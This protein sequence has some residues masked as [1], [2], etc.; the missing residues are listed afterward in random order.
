MTT[1]MWAQMEKTVEN[2][3]WHREA[4]VATH[5]LMTMQKFHESFSS[6]YSDK[7]QVVGLLALLFHDTGKPAAE[8][9]LEKK[10]GSGEKYRRYAG[11]EQESAVV[12][13]QA[14]LS[15]PQ[16]QALV[17]DD[18][19]RAIRWM[20]EHHLPYGYKDKQKRQGL[21]S[22]TFATFSKAGLPYQLFFDCLRS[23]AAG[24]I[25]DDHEKKLNDVEEWISE[26]IKID[27]QCQDVFHDVPLNGPRLFLLSGVSGSGKSTW[28]RS[29]SIVCRD[30]VISYDAYR[31]D[32]YR[33]KN[34]LF[35]NRSSVHDEKAEYMIAWQFC[36]ENSAEFQKFMDAQIN[37]TLKFVSRTGGDIYVDNTNT[38]RKARARFVE[39]AK[40]KK[41]NVI[42]VEFW[43]RFETVVAR[44][45][46]RA[47]KTVPYSALKQQLFSLSLCW[48]GYEVNDVIMVVEQ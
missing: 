40:Q 10:D 32:F 22:A 19:A 15:I 13:Q 27:L 39:L 2:S 31:L 17:N 42:G 45:K 18:E 9:V 11:H 35:S 5:T 34:E 6:K 46:T 26:F 16:L 21:A 38:S 41:F 3:P 29:N 33:W 20:I 23:D 24:R 47:D 36:N 7:A 37:E 30:A 44:Q 14:W 48:L 8:E 28:V 12:F 25:S 43:N 1:E 4:N